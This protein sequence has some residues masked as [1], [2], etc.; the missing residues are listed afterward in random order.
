VHLNL[1]KYQY[2]NYSWQH[3]SRKFIY[4]CITSIYHFMFLFVYHILIEDII[5]I[6]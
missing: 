4:Q 2:F 3:D 6:I 5:I 1:S